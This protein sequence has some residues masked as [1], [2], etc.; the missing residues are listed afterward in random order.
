M[1]KK[2]KRPGGVPKIG[3]NNQKPSN[4]RAVPPSGFPPEDLPYEGKLAATMERIGAQLAE[5]NKNVLATESQLETMRAEGSRM[6]GQIDGIRAARDAYMQEI[7]KE[8]SDAST[9]NGN[10]PDGSGETPQE[11]EPSEVDTEPTPVE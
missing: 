4:L 8:A 1:S 5:L 2:I 11:P 6:L 9:G 3:Q 7:A 10:I